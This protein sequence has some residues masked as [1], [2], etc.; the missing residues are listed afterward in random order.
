MIPL[1]YAPPFAPKEDN[2]FAVILYGGGML[3]SIYF[4]YLA[5][6]KPQTYLDTTTLNRANIPVSEN[7][8]IYA[9]RFLFPASILLWI[10]LFYISFSS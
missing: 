10:F 7:V 9:G 6:F 3:V 1:F 5:W 2:T 4:A 8:R